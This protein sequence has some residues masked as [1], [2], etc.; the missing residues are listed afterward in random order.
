MSGDESRLAPPNEHLFSPAQAAAVCGLRAIDV[1]NA[2]DRGIVS[3]AVRAKLDT[4]VAGLRRGSL[5]LK[6]DDLVRLQ[7]WRGIGETLFLAHRQ[8][9]WAALS[10]TPSA[11]RVRIT[12]LLIVDVELAR[13]QVCEKIGDLAAAEDVIG[14]GDGDLVGEVVFKGTRTL[15]Y[16]TVARIKAGAPSEDILRED[17]SLSRRM[18]DLGML[19]ARAYPRRGRPTLKSKRAQRQQ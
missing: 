10:N 2:I 7:I 13:N 4:G 16:A 14:R 9:L 19:W 18:L 8:K 6:F 17:P 1:Q 12:D 15:V 3:A 5:F 11:K